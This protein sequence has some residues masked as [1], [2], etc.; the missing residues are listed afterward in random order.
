[1]KLLNILQNKLN[2]RTT[3]ELKKDVIESMKSNDETS[4]FIFSAGLSLLEKRLTQ[5]EYEQFENEL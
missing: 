4:I 3:E 2:N 5:F 1:M